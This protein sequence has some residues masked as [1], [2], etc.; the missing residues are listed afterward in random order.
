MARKRD[1]K[2]AAIDFNWQLVSSS[3]IPKKGKYGLI[4]LTNSPRVKTGHGALRLS[5]IIRVIYGF[6]VFMLN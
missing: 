1:L 3:A 2:E 4:V 5:V 6:A